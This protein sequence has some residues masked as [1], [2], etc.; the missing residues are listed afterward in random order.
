MLERLPSVLSTYC[1]DATLLQRELL[2]TLVILE[3]WTKRPRILDV[4]DAIFIHRGGV[5]ARRLA[6]VADLVICGNDYLAER[7][8]QWNSKVAILPM[9][10]D[11]ARFLPNS[12]GASERMVIGW[13]GTSGNFPYL[14]RIE[15]ALA[16]VLKKHP[17]SI[18]RVVA[19]WP[20]Q[21][22]FIRWKAE[23]EVETI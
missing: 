16:Q 12:K 7:F 23:K 3:P 9:A 1:Y 11:T 14:Q 8:A 17:H 13:I 22:E 5:A 18:L 20:H 6:E 21:V 4:G 15:P 2:S 10:V 19:D